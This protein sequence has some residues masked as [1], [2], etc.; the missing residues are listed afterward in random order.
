MTRARNLL[1]L[2]KQ[3]IQLAARAEN[4]AQEL[5]DCSR[6]EALRY[7]SERLAQVIDTVPA[8][9]SATDSQGRVLFMNAYLASLAGIG[10]TEAVGF[11]MRPVFGGPIIM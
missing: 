10:P 11:D 7:S 9:I 6:E 4:L 5:K 1:K 3:Q 8:M 2:R